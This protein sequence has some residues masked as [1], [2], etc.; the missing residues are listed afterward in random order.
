[1]PPRPVQMAM[2]GAA[3]GIKG[4]VRVRSYAADPLGF[5]AYGPLHSED[6]RTFTV[7]E[8]R[9]QGDGVVARF[10]GITDRTAA[11][12]LNGI[13]LF[14]DR[15]ALPDDG[16]DGEFYH[17]DLIGLAVRSPSGEIL[18]KVTAIQ[19]FGGG[20]ILEIVHHG[21]RGVMVPFTLAAVPKVDVATSYIVVD[22]VAAGLADP[23]GEAGDGSDEIP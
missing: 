2:I 17:A 22:P 7:S 1:M 21:R 6:G 19:N 11:E 9:A 13:A 20:D 16:E 10:E 15:T 14:V 4:W 23:D 12:A 8:V 5:G 18:G 3:H